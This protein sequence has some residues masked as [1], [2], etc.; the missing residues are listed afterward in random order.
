MEG[1]IE[2]EPQTTGLSGGEYK[3]RPIEI[4]GEFYDSIHPPKLF[5]APDGRELYIGG[6][7]LDKDEVYA[8]R[9]WGRD[10]PKGLKEVMVENIRKASEESGVFT[11]FVDQNGINDKDREKLSAYRVLARETGYEI[12]EFKLD[13]KTGVASAPIKQVESTVT[14]KS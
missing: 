7:K 6:E 12:G 9:F 8:E 10:Q 13:K 11:S 14:S 3:P 4:D 5:R 2:Q 1:E